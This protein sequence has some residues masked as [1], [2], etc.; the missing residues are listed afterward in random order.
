MRGGHPGAQGLQGE[1]ELVV[2]GQRKRVVHLAR[3]AG[4]GRR[5]LAE[6]L[7]CHDGRGGS[8]RLRALAE[9]R[10]GSLDDLPR[11][12]HGA[13]N[14]RRTVAAF[15]RDV[16]AA[17]SDGDPVERALWTDAA[18][19]LAATAAAAADALPGV[20]PVPVA[21]VGGLFDVGPL[22][23]EPFAAALLRRVPGSRVTPPVG[24]A[25]DGAHLMATRDDLP[26]APLMTCIER[27][28]L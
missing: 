6:A 23:A 11:L 27:G 26:H 9:Q 4:I 1:R 14:V 17:A 16:A 22:L 10:Y 25:I 12:V 13:D 5:A 7:R 15:A 8:E 19:R 18:D 3:W 24:D 21:T 28:T 20:D 2:L